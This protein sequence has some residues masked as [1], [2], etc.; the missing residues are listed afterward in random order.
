MKKSQIKMGEMIAVL[1]V[2][3][4]IVILGFSFYVKFTSRSFA[5]KQKEFKSLQGIDIV[6]KISDLPELHCSVLG[7]VDSSCIDYYKAKFF[8]K[9]TRAKNYKPL[10]YDYFRDSE[11]RMNIIF[12]DSKKESILIYSNPTNST[13][14]NTFLVPSTVYNPVKDE[15]YFGLIEVKIF[16]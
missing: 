6:K 1:L 14:T 15:Y 7:T 9:T 8:F 13:T 11:V 16:Q 12:P 4:I 3:V 10:Y 2:F 5:S